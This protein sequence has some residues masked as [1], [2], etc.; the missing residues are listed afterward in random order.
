LLQRESVREFYAYAPAA[1]DA[2]ATITPPFSHMAAAAPN[3]LLNMRATV[4]PV[5]GLVPDERFA[6]RAAYHEAPPQPRICRRRMI[7][8]RAISI[9]YRH[10]AATPHCKECRRGAAGEEVTEARQEQQHMPVCQR[11]A[12]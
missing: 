9:C 5:T 4:H 12:Q 8:L 6:L 7:C 2:S 1:I 3:V 11:Y 10:T